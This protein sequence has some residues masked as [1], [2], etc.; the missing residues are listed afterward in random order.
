MYTH[1]LPNILRPLSDAVDLVI[2]FQ[3][4]LNKDEKMPK[5][6]IEYYK[7]FEDWIFDYIKRVSNDL[8][9]LKEIK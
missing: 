4:K 9:N 5:N 6:T 8:K 2:D 1:L 7:L 3:Y